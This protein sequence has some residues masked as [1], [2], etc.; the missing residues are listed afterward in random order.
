MM[1]KTLATMMLL[2]LL[3]VSS[4]EAGWDEGV[5]AFKS[6]NYAQAAKEFQAFV[7]ERPDIFQGHYML[8]QTL[9]KLK[10]NQE[11]L[12]HLQKAYELQPGNVGSQ[13]LLG[14]ALIHI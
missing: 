4:L 7:D 6:G 10:R 13:L 2:P 9:S 11:A 1:M 8:G 3:W 12:K 5:A 14:L